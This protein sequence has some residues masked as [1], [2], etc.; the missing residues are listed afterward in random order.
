MKCQFR[1]CIQSSAQSVICDA[2]VFHLCFADTWCAL[3]TLN[4]SAKNTMVSRAVLL[5][6]SPLFGIGICYPNQGAVERIGADWDW[7]WIDVQK[8]EFGYWDV[9]GFVRAWELV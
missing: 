7:L 4:S 8:G 5:K 2:L 1:Y 3:V 6:T 9:F